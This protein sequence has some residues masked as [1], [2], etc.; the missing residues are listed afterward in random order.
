MYKALINATIFTGN[1]MLTGK[2]LL[3]KDDIIEAVTDPLSTPEVAEVI[4]CGGNYLS[5]GLIDLQ[6]AGGGGYL[7][8]SN[9]SV[10][11]L[12]AIT[13]ALVTSGTTGFLIALPTNT[14]DVYREVIRVKYGGTEIT[15]EGEDLLILAGR[16]DILAIVK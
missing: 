8:S 1:E 13:E 5:P 15:I 12:H 14:F 11:A 16:E 2:A 10:E 3:I 9:P 7:F 6:I 4:D